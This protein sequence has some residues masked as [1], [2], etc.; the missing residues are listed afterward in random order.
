MKTILLTLTIAIHVAYNAV[1]AAPTAGFFLPDSVKEITFQY[2]T[3]NNLIILPVTI[4]D[5]MTVN[6]VLDTGCRNLVLFGKRFLN[7][8][9]FKNAREIEFSGL[10]RGATVKGKLAIE[11]KVAFDA[12]EGKRIPII[13]VPS[14]NIFAAFPKIDGLIGYEIFAKFEVEINFAKKLIT[15]RPAQSAQ[16]GS[17]FTVI[18]LRI[19]D[20]RPIVSTC[21]EH[22]LYPNHTMDLLID[23][24][25]S[26]GLL[27]STTEKRKVERLGKDTPLGKGLNGLIQGNQTYA[28]KL[29]FDK[30]VI[31]DV[32]TS[33]VF[34]D[35]HHYASIGI[36]V[37]KDYI[38][39]LNYCKAYAG[40]RQNI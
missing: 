22:A 31:K 18:P 40:L 25:S 39:V 10:G 4:N 35:E 8:F 9:N 12:V 37:L 14:R 36:S 13:V 17:R 15:F 19:E 21:L 29:S 24:G 5:T 34:S 3:I 26:L 7:A 27:L 1:A 32:P 28:Q 23:T 33:I 30:C 6:L 2:K 16:P 20:S 11:N 38:L